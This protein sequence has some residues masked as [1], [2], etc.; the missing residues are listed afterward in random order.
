MTAELW[1]LDFYGQ[2]IRAVGPYI[3]QGNLETSW[4][5]VPVFAKF[6]DGFGKTTPEAV[7]MG[8][9]LGSG[10]QVDIALRHRKVTV[11][12]PGNG[13]VRFSAVI[14]VLA[15][16]RHGRD[17]FNLAQGIAQIVVQTVLIL[18]VTAVFPVDFIV[19]MDRQSRAKH[20]LGLQDCLEM[21]DMKFRRIKIDRV[22]REPDGCAGY[23]AGHL[24]DHFQFSFL[25]SIG[26]ADMVLCTIA[27]DPD[28]ELGGQCG[29]D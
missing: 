13:P 3:F 27:P 14:P 5:E 15:E 12:N 21:G 16:I 22:R 1:F 9:S 19:E 26:K 25:L 7:D 10:H 2:D 28:I 20:R 23:P 4:Q 18:P 8:A 24:I 17:R 11:C 6:P 29:D